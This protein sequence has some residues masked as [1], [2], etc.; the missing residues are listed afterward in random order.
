MFDH[1]VDSN[2]CDL[3]LVLI[4]PISLGIQM[5]LT[6]EIIPSMPPRLVIRIIGFR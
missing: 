6:T 5:R 2:E 4:R 1:S 3:S